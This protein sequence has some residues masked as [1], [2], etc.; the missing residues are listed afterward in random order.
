METRAQIVSRLSNELRAINKDEAYNR[1]TLLAMLE[2]KAIFLLAQRLGDRRLYRESA[3]F[4]TLKC[5]E[6]EKVDII[7]CPFVEFRTCK[8]LMK[9]KLKLPELI[10]SNYG[11]GIINVTSIDNGTVFNQISFRDYTARKRRK[12]SHIEEP[13]YIEMAGYIYIPDH[14]TYAI[15]LQP[16]TLRVEE[17]ADKS[18]CSTEDCCKSYWEYPFLNSDKL[19]ELVFKETLQEAIGTFRSIPVDENPNLDS[20]IKSKTTV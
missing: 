7:S 13:V 10:Y 1:R 5:F 12:Y 14:E 16:L 11:A 20:N 18:T 9:S 8:T 15:D 6:L 4:S 3:I 2:A 17:L 19:K